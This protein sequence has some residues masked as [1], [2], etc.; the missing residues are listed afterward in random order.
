MS[1]Y[2][3]ALSIF[4]FLIA[5]QGCFFQSA[6]T[7]FARDFFYATPKSHSHYDDM[8]ER[9]EHYSL[10]KQYEI[11]L[12][13]MQVIHPPVF[14]FADPIAKRGQEAV[15]FLIAKLTSAD[16]DIEVT[17]ILYIIVEMTFLK[18]TRLP[19]TPYNAVQ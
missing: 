8:A 9:M 1:K 3:V 13:G 15:P 6:D 19:T 17:D 5:I 11:Y 10:E 12:F 7:P 14:E 4:C 16:N 18:S 2:A